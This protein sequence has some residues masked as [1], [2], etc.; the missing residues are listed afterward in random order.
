MT[1]PHYRFGESL[2]R[3]ELDHVLRRFAPKGKIPQGDARKLQILAALH[4]T[5][6]NLLAHEVGRKRG[7]A[8]DSGEAGF[9]HQ[10]IGG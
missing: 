8:F 4:N 1:K 10:R 2:T 7:I 5:V 3:S 9:S 6:P